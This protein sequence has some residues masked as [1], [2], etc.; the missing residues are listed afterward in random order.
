MFRIS[1]DQKRQLAMF[2]CVSIILF[3]TQTSSYLRATFISLFVCVAVYISMVLK[4]KGKE[5]K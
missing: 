1:S 2:F 4:N 5:S 3:Y